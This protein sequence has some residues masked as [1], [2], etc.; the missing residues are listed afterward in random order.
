MGSATGKRFPS[1]YGQENRQPATK[2][3]LR[4]RL[5]QYLRLRR[6]EESGLVSSKNITSLFESRSFAM[7]YLAFGLFFTVGVVLATTNVFGAGRGCRRRRR[8]R[9]GGGRC[10]CGGGRRRGRCRSGRCSCTCFGCGRSPRHHRTAW[11]A[12]RRTPANHRP[13][14]SRR[15]LFDPCFQDACH[16]AIAYFQRSGQF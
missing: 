5:A 11:P 7:R 4:D 10:G 14:Q 6:T 8:R 12:K 3:A 15:A 16:R 9:S 13:N 2:C 1:I